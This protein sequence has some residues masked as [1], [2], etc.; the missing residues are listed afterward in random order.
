MT[1]PELSPEKRKQAVQVC[2]GLIHEAARIESV[3][4]DAS[5]IY[6]AYCQEFTAKTK[7]AKLDWGFLFLATAL[8]M[9]RQYLLTSFPERLD[10][11]AGARVV[12]GE[13]AI[14]KE[15]ADRKANPRAHSYY[16]PSIEEILCQPVPFDA[17]VGSDGALK[18]GGS[19]GHRAM[20]PGHDPVVGLVIGTANIAT[21]TLTNWR[22]ES[23]HIKS[24]KRKNGGMQDVFGNRANTAKVLSTTIDKLIN[25]G[26]E[27][28]Q[29]VALALGKEI[30]HLRSDVNTKNGLPL[31]T[32]GALSPKLASQLAEYGADFSNVLTVG[33]QAAVAVAINTII[34]MA[35]GL[36]YDPSLDGDIKL[37]K[38]RTEKILI[39]SNAIAS[40]SN[41]MV[42]W[43]TR[44]VRNLDLGGYAVALGKLV[45]GVDFIERVRKGFIEGEFEKLINSK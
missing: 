41:A 33:K 16:N 32:V 37:Y 19:L 14:A 44:N 6:D 27:G 30:V 3:C 38:V 5:E 43:A 2:D 10:D 7:L 20:T 36:F 34:A 21:S 35:H 26:V 28:K 22:F 24:G 4:W 12:E 1:R 15:V 42:V 8:Q 18:G 40:L 13:D 31:P 29:K 23:W 39:Y 25:Q 17:N 45:T 11:Q 9:L